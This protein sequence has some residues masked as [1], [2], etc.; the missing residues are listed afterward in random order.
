MIQTVAAR[1]RHF[2]DFDWLKTYWLFSFADYYDPANIQFGALR[3]YNDDVVAPGTGFPTHPHREMEIVTVV[4]DGEMTHADSMGNRTVIGAGDV[5]RMSAGTGL[6]HSEFNLAKGPVHFHQ[7][8][9]YPDRRD[10]TPTYDQRHFE[11]EAWRDRLLPVASGQ[12]LSGAVSFHTDA[13]IYRCDLS[14]GR[15]LDVPAAENRRLFLYL[16][17]GRL[18]ANG[19]PLTAGDQARIDL[20]PALALRA[21]GDSA[22][23]LI[24]VPSCR[25]WG[26][27]RK[28]LSGARA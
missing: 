20:E 28:T 18:D 9:L 25:G 8:W 3:V 24:D 10:L 21:A 1:R 23:V 7:I 17:A 13:T 15:T 11:P 2:S 27:D 16:I 12:G 5:Q 4:L 26:Y 6:T 22:F 19:S 14:A